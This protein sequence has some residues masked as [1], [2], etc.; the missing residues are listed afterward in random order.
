MDRPVQEDEPARKGGVGCVAVIVGVLFLLDSAIDG[1][2]RAGRG[3]DGV[4]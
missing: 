2:A 4:S 1:G 3:A